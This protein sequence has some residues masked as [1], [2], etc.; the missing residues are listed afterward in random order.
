MSDQISKKIIHHRSISQLIH[1]LGKTKSRK[2]FC[3]FCIFKTLKNP[4]KKKNSQM[5]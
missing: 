3:D 5:T 1:N 4:F 2:F